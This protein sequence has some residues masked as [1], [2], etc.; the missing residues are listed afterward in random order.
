MIFRYQQK[1]DLEGDTGIVVR[2][3]GTAMALVKVSNAPEKPL[4][5]VM[6]VG[7]GNKEAETQQKT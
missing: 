1:F 7:G 4:T 2:G 6:P 5:N 3:I